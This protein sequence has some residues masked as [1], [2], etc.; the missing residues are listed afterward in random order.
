MKKYFIVSDTHACT[1]AT[2]KINVLVLNED[3]L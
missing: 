1:A 3:E 2:N